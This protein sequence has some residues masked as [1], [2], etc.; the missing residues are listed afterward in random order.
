MSSA[1]TGE[2]IIIR[3]S[4]DELN[5]RPDLT[6]TDR[7]P[8]HR[9]H[10]LSLSTFK[11]HPLAAN[12]ILDFPPFTTRT[13]QTRQL[14]QVMDDTLVVLVSHYAIHWLLQG[15]GAIIPAGHTGIEEE[16]V[17][18]NWKTGKVVAVS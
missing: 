2:L 18:W 6:H 4:L 3:E 5:C 13:N 15:L 8:T 10:L 1:S 16:I 12:H 17:C 7:G 14:L 11:P 9:Y